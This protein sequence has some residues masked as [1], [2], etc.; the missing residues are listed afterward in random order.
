LDPASHEN[1]GWLHYTQGDFVDALDKM[2]HAVS[3]DPEYP[4]GPM[5]VGV[6]LNYSG[7]APEAVPYLREALRLNPHDAVRHQGNLGM[8]YANAGRFEEAL[9]SFTAR[10][11]LQPSPGGYREVGDLYLADISVP[12]L[13]TEGYGP[14]PDFRLGPILEVIR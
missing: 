11:T 13:L 1:L 5:G 4:L 9:A 8:A 12:P 2:E 14:V 3:L 7:R 6:V 10:T